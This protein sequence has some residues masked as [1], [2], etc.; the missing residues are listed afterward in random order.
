MKKVYSGL[1]MLPTGRADESITEGCIVLEGGGWKG[2]Y[3]LG[4][5]DYLMEQNINFRSTVGISAGALSGLGYVTGQIGWGAR[6]DLTYRHDKNYCG[7]GAVKR[8][9]GVTG[10]SYLY[11]DIL[12]DLPFDKKRFKETEREFAV[13]LT[14]MVTGMIEYHEKGT[15]N[16]SA[17]IRASATVPFVSRPVVIGGMPYLDGGCSEKIPFSWAERRGEKKIVVVKTR[18]RE[19]RNF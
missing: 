15:C 11:N 9:K 4:V 14:N 5:L 6:V 1:D 17:A 18:E 13:G 3:T 19:F 7:L 10:F 2:L 8:D 16:M 12:K